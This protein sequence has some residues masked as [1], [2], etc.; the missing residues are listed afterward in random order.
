[1]GLLLTR[2]FAHCL[3]R[4]HCRER[5]LLPTLPARHHSCACECRR[6]LCVAVC[7]SGLLL[8]CRVL[9]LRG[10]RHR[11]G[12]ALHLVGFLS[13]LHRFR[14]LELVNCNCAHLLLNRHRRL[15]ARQHS[16]H[17]LFHHRHLIVRP[18]WLTVNPVE[19][20][21]HCSVL[22]LCGAREWRRRALRFSH[23]F[24]HLHVL[25]LL[26][27]LFLHRLIARPELLAV[28]PV[29]VLLRRLCCSVVQCGDVLL[30]AVTL[31][32]RREPL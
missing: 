8:C 1:M 29:D 2:Q 27:L 10:R 17:L 4:R 12:C 19:V 31:K 22:H 5:A 32:K 3:Q 26:L 9:H 7:C 16:T 15:L 21:V 13:K 23:F 6:S 18:Q 30:C 24:S 25:L 20:V 11:C 14:V 28:N